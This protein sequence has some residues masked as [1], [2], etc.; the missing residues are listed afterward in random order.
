MVTPLFLLG[1]RQAARQYHLVERHSC[2]YWQVAYR[3]ST[4]GVEAWGSSMKKLGAIAVV[5]GGVVGGAGGGGGRHPAARQSP[6]G[7]GGRAGA[8]LPA[9]CPAPC[10]TP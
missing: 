1:G 2:N 6:T 9:R 5:A 4:L 3:G 8:P 10:D 7:G